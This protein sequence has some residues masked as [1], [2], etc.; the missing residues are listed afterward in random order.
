MKTRLRRYLSRRPSP[1]SCLPVELLEVVFSYYAHDGGTNLLAIDFTETFASTISSHPASIVNPM[2]LGE[3][4]QQWR[5][6]SRSLPLLWSKIYISHPKED[7]VKRS[8]F[9]L[10]LARNFPLTIG[11]SSFSGRP[12]SEDVSAME[13][14]LDLFISNYDTWYTV[15]IR[16]S[17][18]FH[19]LFFRV[20]NYPPPSL[21]SVRLEI[22]PS[23]PPS[24]RDE[25]AVDILYSSKALR[26]IAWPSSHYNIPTALAKFPHWA[27]LTHFVHHQV[28]LQN[29]LTV[30]DTLAILN[31]CPVLESFEARIYPPDN[32][33]LL[34]PISLPLMH[35]H[36]RSLTAATDTVLLPRV[37]ESL[38]LP[39]L[40]LLAVHHTQFDFSNPVLKSAAP[41]LDLLE[42]S[43]CTLQGFDL[44]TPSTQ[45]DVILGLIASPQ[46]QNVS[47]IR[48]PGPKTERTISLLTRDRN[49]P[50]SLAILP[51]LKHLTFYSYPSFS[52]G[53]NT[54]IKS[55][56]RMLLSR[57]NKNLLS[58]V[59]SGI[60]M[61]LLTYASLGLSRLDF[62]DYSQLDKLGNADF[63]IL[64]SQCSNP[65]RLDDKLD[66]ESVH[67][68]TYFYS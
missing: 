32:G 41:I 47:K 66:S 49:Y 62:W 60:P 23:Y 39:A 61:S 54:S 40:E 25:R 57:R 55:I 21:H 15:D 7:H 53:L 68:N 65:S 56:K 29:N 50:Q 14:L 64:P 51:L 48:L 17:R 4:S 6:I 37:L 45:E 12:T 28:F 2:T 24:P 46:L 10:S 5:Q 31:T 52:G 38:I 59:D 20:P 43:S 33:E 9:W 18:H 30:N 42:R 36:L 27:A 58:S 35:S 1:I 44:A 11:I 22:G 16:V 34:H 67:A 13:R 63:K 8:I 19:A 3:V 26:K